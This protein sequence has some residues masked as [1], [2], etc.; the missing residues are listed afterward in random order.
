MGTPDPLADGVDWARRSG[1]LSRMGTTED[2]LARLRGSATPVSVK[3]ELP[4][5][6]SGERPY[7][8]LAR[9]TTTDGQPGRIT[10]NGCTERGVTAGG[11]EP[12]ATLEFAAGPARELFF[13]L[14][15]E[16]ASPAV[17]G[18]KARDLCIVVR[19]SANLSVEGMAVVP[20]ADDLPPPPPEPWEAT[21]TPLPPDRSPATGPPPARH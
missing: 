3:L 12:A 5:T 2:D 10:F 6:E 18:K 1:L 20:L 17:P 9:A 15:R 8:L 11:A 14:P 4:L 16:V 13:E 7:R 21:P 19:R